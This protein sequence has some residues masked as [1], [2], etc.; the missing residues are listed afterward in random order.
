MRFGPL[1][2]FFARPAPEVGR[3]LIGW[4]FFVN[5][6]GGEIVETE[7]Y[8]QGD[9]ASHSFR[10]QTKA[11]AAMFGPPGRAYVYRIYGLHLCLNF[12]CRDAGAVLLRALAPSRGESIMAS[13]RRVDRDVLFCSGPGRL[14]QALAIQPGMNGLSLDAAPFHLEPP[15]LPRPVIT[16]P[17][18]G[19]SRA[20]E[21]PWRFG[22]AGS[23]H[24]SKP[25]PFPA[26]P[27]D[28][29]G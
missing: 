26:S 15:T 16:G 11:N 8:T 29:E 13:R 21:R 12:V 9:E 20:R 7:A 6:V 5:D 27:I 18:I 25:F 22:L 2:E 24:L 14:A 1:Q 23:P 28:Q 4:H 19:I 10:G 17:R 3:D